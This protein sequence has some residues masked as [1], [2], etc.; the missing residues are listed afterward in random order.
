MAEARPNTKIL[1]ADA[2]TFATL[3]TRASFCECGGYYA[4]GEDFG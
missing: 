4:A 2:M 3:G 1:R